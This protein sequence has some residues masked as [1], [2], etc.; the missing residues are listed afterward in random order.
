MSNSLNFS[1]EFEKNAYYYFNY[2]IP[3]LYHHE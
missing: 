1:Q 2:G 3:N